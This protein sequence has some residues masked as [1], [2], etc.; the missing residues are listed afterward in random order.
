MD[1][2]DSLT[3]FGRSTEATAIDSH[4]DGVNSRWHQVLKQEHGDTIGKFL[5]LGGR[6][7]TGDSE[8]SHA[9]VAHPENP[10]SCGSYFLEVQD[11]CLG[12]ICGMKDIK[13]MRM[14]LNSRWLGCHTT[15]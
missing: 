10:E 12:C 11:T 8:D 6:V 4:G 7:I 15:P 2:L 13:I 3:S 5:T 9:G 14:V 1:I